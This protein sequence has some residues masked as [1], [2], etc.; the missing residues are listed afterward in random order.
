MSAA[1][2]E[3]IEALPPLVFLVNIVVTGVLMIYSSLNL[4]PDLPAS[5]SAH[6]QI[7]HRAMLYLTFLLPTAASTIYL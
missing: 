1:R 7:Y 3:R 2:P 5:A 6:P 4:R